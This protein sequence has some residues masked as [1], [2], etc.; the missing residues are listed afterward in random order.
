MKIGSVLRGLLPLALT[1]V[2][3]KTGHALAH[4][5]LKVEQDDYSTR[6]C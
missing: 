5:D 1:L 6:A 4:G 2:L 3:T